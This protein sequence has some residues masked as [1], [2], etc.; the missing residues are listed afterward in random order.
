MKL[1]FILAATFFFCG[2]AQIPKKNISRPDSDFLFPNG[3]YFQTAI[4][5]IKTPGGNKNFDFNAVIHKSDAE[6][7]F[8][9][10]S[11]FGISLFKIH[12]RGTD[13]V[14]IES[15]IAE[16]NQNKD[17]FINI[18]FLVKEI[19]FIQI[20]NPKLQNH[21]YNIETGAIRARVKF[22]EFDAQKIPL[23]FEITTTNESHI[24][25]KTTKYEFTMDKDHH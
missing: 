18:F 2:C 11:D 16:I 17:F 13:P 24:T 3:K 4:A 15:S 25:I 6:V 1:K 8:Y 9:G 12:Q 20:S 7:N 14:E 23:K 22:S 5:A 19:I 10:F 21:E